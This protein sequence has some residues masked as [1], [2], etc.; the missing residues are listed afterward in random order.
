MLIVVSPESCLLSARLLPDTQ[1]RS[2]KVGGGF[3]PEAPGRG[4]MDRFTD[5]ACVGSREDM[6]LAKKILR[7]P[8]SRMYLDRWMMTGDCHSETG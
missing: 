3:P 6:L 2:P 4:I 7:T 8:S 1:S 5:R